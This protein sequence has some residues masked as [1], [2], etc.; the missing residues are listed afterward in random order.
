[1]GLFGFLR[2]STLDVEED[3]RPRWSWPG[4]MP[5]GYLPTG[6]FDGYPIGSPEAVEAMEHY[7]WP[8]VQVLRDADGM[9]HGTAV[10]DENSPLM[11]VSGA[12]LRQELG[13]L[14][15]ATELKWDDPRN[16]AKWNGD[17]HDARVGPSSGAEMVPSESMIDAIMDRMYGQHA[18]KAVVVCEHCGQF[19]A[20][21][22]ACRQCGAPVT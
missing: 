19:G 21:F 17:T 16:L 3:T 15:A 10:M 9:L 4:E 18:G 1:M 5:D 8:K 20:R 14:Y 13:G 2:K 7:P 22:C 6:N 11:I 12:V